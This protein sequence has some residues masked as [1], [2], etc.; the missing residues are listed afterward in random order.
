MNLIIALLNSTGLI[1]QKPPLKKKVTKGVFLIVE[2][3]H[4][5]KFNYTSLYT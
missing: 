2:I 5:D 4:I 1:F 3:K